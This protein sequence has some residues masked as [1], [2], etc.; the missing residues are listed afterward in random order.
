VTAKYRPVFCAATLLCLGLF[1]LPAPSHAFDLAFTGDAAQAAASSTNGQHVI[2]TGPHLNGALPTRLAAGLV[3]Q[4]T[5]QIA[6]TTTATLT[7]ALTD[8]LTAQGYTITFTCAARICGGFDF[9]HALSVGDVP[10]MYVDLSDFVYITA[11][12][13]EDEE[14]D[15]QD[16][17]LMISQGGS[18][19]F[20]HMAMIQPE[21]TAATPVVI[22]SRAPDEEVIPSGGL[23]AQLLST[24]AAPLDDLQFQT[25]ASQL[26]GDDFTSLTS[27]ADFLNADSTR[28]VVLVGHT[29]ASGSLSGNIAL[30]RARATA[31]QR[32]LTGTLGVSSAQVEAQGIGFLSPRASNTTPEGRETNRRVE[33]V[34]A[35]TQ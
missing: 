29:D 7:T 27:L 6:D 5:W 28:R 35:T 21:G 12:R 10:E 13:E 14:E 17:A 15:R 3:Q 11:E 2:A 32:Y 30:S 9:R 18:T 16:V 22:S 19:G 20:V 31:V 34:L 4:T 8:Q 26:S 33:V 25:G 1:G 24:G 23:I